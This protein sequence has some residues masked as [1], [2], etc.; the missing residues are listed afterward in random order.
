MSMTRLRA[1]PE[2]F[3]AIVFG[4]LIGIAVNIFSINPGTLRNM[5][6]SDKLPKMSS[7]PCSVA[8]WSCLFAAQHHFSLF[9]AYDLV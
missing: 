2:P 5:Q 9:F 1:V 4:I 6:V 3:I 7:A 8:K